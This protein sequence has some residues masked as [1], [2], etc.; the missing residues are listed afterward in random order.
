MISKWKSIANIMV[1][2]LLPNG[3]NQWVKFYLLTGIMRS[4]IP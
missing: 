4:W 1:Q 3:F 2:I